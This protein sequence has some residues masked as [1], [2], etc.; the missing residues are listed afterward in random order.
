MAV[1]AQDKSP[2]ITDNLLNHHQVMEIVAASGIMLILL[3]Y[4]CFIVW[5]TDRRPIIW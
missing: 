1:E 3:Y 4:L 5:L 2:E